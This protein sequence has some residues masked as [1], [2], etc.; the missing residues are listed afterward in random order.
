MPQ[1]LLSQLQG[2]NCYPALKDAVQEGAGEVTLSHQHLQESRG[3]CEEEE[4]LVSVQKPPGQGR[5]A[6]A[7]D[8]GQE[9]FQAWILVTHLETQ[10]FS[11]LHLQS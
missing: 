6:A 9:T 10:Y 4:V 2:P 1:T 8:T 7:E 5:G 11:R 3:S